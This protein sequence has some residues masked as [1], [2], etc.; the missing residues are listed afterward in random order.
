MYV[1]DVGAGLYLLMRIPQTGNYEFAWE[2]RKP[3]LRE[4]RSVTCPDGWGLG[5]LNVQSPARKSPPGDTAPV[6]VRTYNS[7]HDQP[8]EVGVQE[9][10]LSACGN[11]A[12]VSRKGNRGR[13]RW[14]VA[15]V[16]GNDE[17]TTGRH[18]LGIH[19][20]RIEAPANFH[21]ELRTDVHDGG[22]RGN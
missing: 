13:A 4:A 16:A 22:K 18:V 15:R 7:P 6:V 3:Q 9:R 2:S 21:P 1:E 11:Q 17:S 10:S 20:P 12:R 19:C 8:G 14:L 5:R